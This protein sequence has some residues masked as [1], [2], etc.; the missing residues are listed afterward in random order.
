MRL[1]RLVPALAAGALLTATTSPVL[2]QSEPPDVTGV[3]TTTGA[4]TLLDLDA[5][6]LL[7]LQLL[8]DGGRANIDEAVGARSAAAQIAALALDTAATDPLSVPLLAVESTGEPQQT[9]QEVAIP[10]NPLVS[11]TALPLSLSALVD[12]AG[13]QSTLAAALADLDVLGGILGI[14]GTDLDLGSNALVADADGTRGITVDALTALDLE[15]LLAGLGI[16]LTD[17]PLD[18]LLGLLDGLGLLDQLQPVLDALGLDVADLSVESIVGV[19]DGVVD[20]AGG[21]VDQVDTLTDQLAALESLQADLTGTGGGAGVTC[22]VTDPGLDVLGDLLGGGATPTQLCTDVTGT[23]T[24]VTSQLT[25][26]EADLT[27][28]TD[29]LDGLLDQVDGLTDAV[30]GL[31]DG[32]ALLQLQ[33]LDVNVLTKATDDV[34]TS[35]A[36]V[37]AS[38]GSLQVGELSLPGIELAEV[39]APVDALLAQVEG[40]IGDVLGQIGGGQLAEIVSLRTLEETTSVEEADG[41]VTSSAD[42]TGLVVEVLP[43]LADLDGLLAGLGGADSLGATLQG[44]GLP[45]PASGATEV[46]GLSSLLGGVTGGVPVLAALEDGLTMRIASLSQQSAFTPVAAPGT[47]GAPGAPGSPAPTLPRTGSSDTLVLALAGAAV[48]AA[49]GG[50]WA[51]R[52]SSDA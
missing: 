10:A 12:D 37:T 31:L 20:E 16:P 23:L 45:V 34:A 29:L 50:R 9:G 7:S 26:L 51:L 15:A 22:D 39:T 6:S 1:S 49:L 21:L 35:V 43:A 46:L 30:L 2:A 27:E 17:L 42:F 11:G 38:I 32:Q 41:R 28:V 52:R 5:G 19:V 14:E 24:S 48:L 8:T 4:L 33:G 40:A 25:A 3:G 47:P 13:A 44:L 36:D 18:D